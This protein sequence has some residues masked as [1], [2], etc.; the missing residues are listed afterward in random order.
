LHGTTPPVFHVLWELIYH[1]LVKVWN[2]CHCYCFYNFI[3]QFSLAS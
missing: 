3:Q 2:D 1:F